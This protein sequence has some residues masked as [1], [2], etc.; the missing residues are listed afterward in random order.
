MPSQAILE[1]FSTKMSKIFGAFGAILKRNNLFLV[2]NRAE[3]KKVS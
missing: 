2:E 1:L 3:N